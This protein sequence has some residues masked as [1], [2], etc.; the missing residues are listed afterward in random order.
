MSSDADSVSQ[1]SKGDMVLTLLHLL[2]KSFNNV[3]AAV[4]QCAMESNVVLV[5]FHILL[6]CL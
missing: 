5:M 4:S 2:Y 6:M 1:R 3:T